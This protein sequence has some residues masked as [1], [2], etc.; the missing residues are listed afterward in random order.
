LDEE[1]D[2]LDKSLKPEDSI[3]DNVK[4]VFEAYAV[5]E[6][7]RKI[8]DSKKFAELGVHPSGEAFKKLPVEFKNNIPSFINQNVNLKRLENVR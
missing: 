2:K 1:F 8:I 3:Y 7:F 5:D 6:E 4:E